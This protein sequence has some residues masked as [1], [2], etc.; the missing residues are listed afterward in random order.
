[1]SKIDEVT[2]IARNLAAMEREY[3]QNLETIAAFKHK[4]MVAGFDLLGTL[5][6]GFRII[7][8][9]RIMGQLT[10]PTIAEV[11]KEKGLAV[12]VESEDS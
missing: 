9:P 5:D 6:V 3:K 2:L 8:E 1:M 12:Q 4:L 11:H 7:A 10:V